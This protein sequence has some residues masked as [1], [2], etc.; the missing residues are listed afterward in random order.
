MIAVIVGTRPEI[1]KMS[2]IVKELDK[3][4]MDY[5]VL[6]TGQHYSYELDNI[7]M[8]QLKMPLPKYNLHVGSYSSIK[9]TT[10]M[11]L[12]LEN[13]LSEE[14]PDMVL[15]LGD[16]NTI[17]SSVLVANKLKIKIGHIEAGLRSYDKNMPEESN[18]IIADH[19]ADMLFAPTS[20][21]YSIL[22]HE[23]IESRKVFVTGNPIVDAVYQNIELSNKMNI[24][25]QYESK[26]YFLATAHRTENVDNEKRFK[27]LIESLKEVHKEF[28]LP[29]IYP[30]HPHS[31]NKVKQ[32]GLSLDG[33]EIIEPVGYFEFLQLESNARLILT[34]SGGVQEE[35]CIIG[36]PCITLRD[37]TERPETID[38][39][40]NILGGVEYGKIFNCV[41]IMLQSTNHWVSPFGDGKAAKK[42]VEILKEN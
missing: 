33:L 17:L 40:A 24:K 29:I 41:N 16:T 36:V 8:R 28:G 7:F 27:S 37:N 11:M 38:V 4:N 6:H 3:Q 30:I 31:K 15:V 23:G 20:K 22:L 34:D 32:Y 9:Q 35:S 2:P 5:F 25:A 1:I 18:R 13:V 19:L 10:K 39:D 14:K 21:A 42:I 12:G 26:K